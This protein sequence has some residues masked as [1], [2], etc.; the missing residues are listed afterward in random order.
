MIGCTSQKPLQSEQA[1]ESSTHLHIDGLTTTGHTQDGMAHLQINAASALRDDQANVINLHD[2]HAALTHRN[3][4]TIKVSTP[5][6]LWKEQ[7]SH[8]VTTT[9][10]VL[11]HQN[12]T[13]HAQSGIAELNR[14][15]LFF[16]GPICHTLT[17]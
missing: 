11:T 12:S 15:R 5:Q 4:H 3:M 1:D 17:H 9:P 14:K 13:L 6:A 2:V 8:L 16:R 7:S 10:T